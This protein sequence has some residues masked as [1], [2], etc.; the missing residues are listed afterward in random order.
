MHSARAGRKHTKMLPVI[1]SRWYNYGWFSSLLFCLSMLAAINMAFI[2]RENDQT[3]DLC[4][5][6]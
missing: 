1:I 6:W 3:F 2:I 4:F 5:L